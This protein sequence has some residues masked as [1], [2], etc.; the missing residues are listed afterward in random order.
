MNIRAHILPR[1]DWKVMACSLAI[2][3]A[4]WVAAVTLAGCSGTPLST[5]EKG[6][7]A[8]GAIG[9]GTGAIIGSAV[10]APGAGAAIGGT[11]GAGTGFVVGN[12]LQN[13]EIRNSQTQAQVSAQQQEINAQHSEIERLKQQQETE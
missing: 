3:T 13:T 1:T 12:A 4:L 5:R 10:G 9:A 2:A 11:L 8:G 7:I 6:T